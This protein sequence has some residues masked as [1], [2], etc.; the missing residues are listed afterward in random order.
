[1]RIVILMC[2]MG[3]SGCASLGGNAFYTYTKVGNDCSVKIDSGRVLKAGATLSIN[4]CNITVTANSLEQGNG[5]ISEVNN[6]ITTLGLLITTGKVNDTTG[7]N[8]A[9]ETTVEGP[10]PE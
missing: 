8:H 7:R 2:L 10:R 5:S 6:L 4:K 3:L 9:S 1:M